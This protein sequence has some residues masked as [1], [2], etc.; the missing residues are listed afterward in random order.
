MNPVSEDEAYV[1]ETTAERERES[2]KYGVKKGNRMHVQTATEVSP[3]WARPSCAA[4]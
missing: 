3:L 2:E 4:L 1:S